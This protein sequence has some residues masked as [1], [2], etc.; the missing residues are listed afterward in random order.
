MG[1]ATVVCL[2]VTGAQ[3]AAAAALTLRLALALGNGWA[4]F[5]AVPSFRRQ[6][7]RSPRLFSPA[8]ARFLP[9]LIV[10]RAAS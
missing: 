5:S 4:S 6:R 3:E 7:A 9:K 2:A 10:K 1:G 8:T